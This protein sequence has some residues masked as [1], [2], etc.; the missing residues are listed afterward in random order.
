[1][2]TNESHSVDEV[3]MTKPAVPGEWCEDCTMTNGQ[4][5]YACMTNW[6]DTDIEE[7]EDEMSLPNGAWTED[8]PTLTDQ[9][10]IYGQH[11]GPRNTPHRF[12]FVYTDGSPVRGSIGAW[13]SCTDCEEA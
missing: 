5:T 12:R 2:S 8:S 3:D 7:E 10:N 4:H 11:D 9:G 6:T 13:I 1:M